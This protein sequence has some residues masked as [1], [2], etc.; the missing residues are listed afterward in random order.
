MAIS[1]NAVSDEQGAELGNIMRARSQRR[2]GRSLG[3]GEVPRSHDG[4]SMSVFA[5][6]VAN[7]DA[8]KWQVLRESYRVREARRIEDASAKGCVP[9]VS[10]DNLNDAAS[11]RRA[12]VRIPISLSRCENLRQRP[13][14]IDIRGQGLVTVPKLRVGS[15]V[16]SRAHRQQLSH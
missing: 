10:R 11:D 14:R 16:E 7:R 4:G 3:A 15:I 9:G 13:Q 5:G 12:G 8:L 2:P 6:Q 1:S